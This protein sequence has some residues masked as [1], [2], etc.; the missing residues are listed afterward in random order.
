MLRHLGL[1]A[2][3]LAA[4]ASSGASPVKRAEGVARRFAPLPPRR[5]GNPVV[6]MRTNHGTIRIELFEK[7]APLTAKNFLRYVDDGFYDGTVFHRVIESFMIQGGGHTKD[8]KPKVTRPAVANE[9]ANGLENKRGTVAVARAAAPDSGTSQFYINVKDNGFLD[10]KNAADKVGYC[11]FGKVI[12]GMDVVDKIK[13]VKTGV[14][15]AMR[16]V[17]TEPVEIV[18]MKRAR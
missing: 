10:R 13:A 8:M 5:V 11:V 12:D 14:N 15:G 6:E 9:S 2:V 4:C 7:E 1:V 16:D 18:S 17:P 3:V